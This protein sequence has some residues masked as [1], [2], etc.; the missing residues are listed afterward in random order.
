[1]KNIVETT[2]E[3]L[4]LV[5]EFDLEEFEIETKDAK[6]KLSTVPPSSRVTVVPQQQSSLEAQVHTIGRKD[7]EAS[8]TSSSNDNYSNISSPMVGTFYRQSAPD[9]PPYVE[10]GQRVEP[11]QPVCI[12]EA[13]KLMN[14][15]KADIS[16]TIVQIMVKNE[17][18][19]Q[20]GDVLFLIK[21]T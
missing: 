18:A 20:E 15:I 11:G 5:K 2:S 14:E 6:I 7:F 1:M 10:V 3:I 4:E 9:K 13:M 19:V 12:I 16:G 8:D 21:P 17:D